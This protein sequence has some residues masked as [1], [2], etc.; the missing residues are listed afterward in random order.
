MSVLPHCP[1][2][3]S[4]YTYED[5]T[6][7]II[8]PECGYEFTLEQLDKEDIIKDSVGN[9]LQNGDSVTITK[10]LSVKGATKAIKKGTKVKSIKFID[11]S[12]NNDHDIEAKVDGFGTI[13]L[14]S[15]VVKKN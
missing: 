4:P 15:S 1:K 6:G 12:Q 8:C 5:G 10:D 13:L 14:K 3:D 2:C 11:P 9:T 7:L